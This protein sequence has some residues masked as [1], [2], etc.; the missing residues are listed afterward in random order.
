MVVLLKFQSRTQMIGPRK[1]I[2]CSNFTL[3]SQI[4]ATTMPV[5]GSQ[6]Y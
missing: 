1:Q 2:V 5:F 6:C 4:T 3:T